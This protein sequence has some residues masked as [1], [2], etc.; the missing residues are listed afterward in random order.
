MG[1]A[2]PPRCVDADDVFEG[3]GV[4]G[5]GPCHTLPPIGELRAECSGSNVEVREDA[6][7]T[8]KAVMKD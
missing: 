1:R 3:V 6:V 5:A 2:S 4:A 7:W 8:V